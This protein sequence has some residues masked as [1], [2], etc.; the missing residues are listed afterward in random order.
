MSLVCDGILESMSRTF[1]KVDYDQALDLTVR[2][3]DCLPPNHL[4]RFVVEVIDGLDLS[5]MRGS[6][7]GSGSAS[8]PSPFEVPPVQ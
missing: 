5:V 4:A 6:Y 7:R 2:L 3:G 1:K 8:H